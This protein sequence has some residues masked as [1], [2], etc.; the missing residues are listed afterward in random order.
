MEANRNPRKWTDESGRVR[1][2]EGRHPS[3]PSRPGYNLKVDGDWLGTFGTLDG[4][5]NAA[6]SYVR[7]RGLTIV[8]HKVVLHPYVDPWGPGGKFVIDGPRPVEPDDG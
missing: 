8:D 2:I 3:E 1:V 4:A 7:W 6:A 5:A